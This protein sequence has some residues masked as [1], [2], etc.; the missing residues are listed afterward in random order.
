MLATIPGNRLESLA[1]V[2]SAILNT[3]PGDPLATTAVMVHHP[4]IQH[5]LSMEL[6][7]EDRQGICMNLSFPMPVEQFWTLIRSI[8]GAEIPAHKRNMALAWYSVTQ[9]FSGVL[10]STVDVCIEQERK[11]EIQ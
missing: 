4:D 2:L 5:W 11:M 10:A 9:G 6:A 1:D 3:E 8:L 7:K